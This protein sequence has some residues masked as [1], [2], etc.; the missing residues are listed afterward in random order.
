M[1]AETVAQQDAITY[2]P[3]AR[4]EE[5]SSH[6]VA[7]S[8]EDPTDAVSRARRITFR[9]VAWVTTLFLLVMFPF[10]LLEI[11]MMWLPDE[12][13]L[14]LISDLT[15]SD[16]VHR[17]HF[18]SVGI[19]MWA[20]L[21]G[22][23]VQLRRPER[24]AAAML[25][26]VV[27]VVAGTVLFGLTGTLDEFLVEDVILLVP[28]V[29]LALL[30]PRSRE[31]FGRQELE[32][33]M[34]ALAAVAVLPWSVFA[35]DQIRL[36]ITD[37]STHAELEHWAA[38]A[39]VAIVIVTFGFIGSTALPGWKLTAWIAAAASVIYGLNSLSFPAPASALSAFWAAAALLWGVAFAVTI[40]RRGRRDRAAIGRDGSF[41]AAS[42]RY[43]AHPEA[44]DGGVA[45]TVDT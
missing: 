23:A 22:V 9:I 12:T 35:V 5:L 8:I 34:A 19:V 30:H 42:H 29:L 43:A 40:V 20:L 24:R 45:R 44:S 41:G 26:S 28:V 14:T 15:E 25:H 32:P 17:T 37:S 16:L 21:L 18:L 3:S 27:I 1:T 33:M 39:L 2:R 13:L 7:E 4:S 31:L 6:S 10:S 11:V 36:Q 38:A